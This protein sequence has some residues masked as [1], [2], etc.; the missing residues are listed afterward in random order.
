MN[1]FYSII[2][3]ESPEE[4]EQHHHHKAKVPSCVQSLI[5]TVFMSLCPLYFTML[6]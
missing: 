1:V 6:R 4:M 3:I 2:E 5:E